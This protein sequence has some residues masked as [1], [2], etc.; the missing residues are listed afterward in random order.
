MVKGLVLTCAPEMDKY[1]EID[2]LSELDVLTE[3]PND[4]GGKIKEYEGAKFHTIIMEYPTQESVDSVMTILT[5]LEEAAPELIKAF[6]WDGKK[7]VLSFPVLKDNPKDNN[8]YQ[9]IVNEL[10]RVTT[11]LISENNNSLSIELNQTSV[12]EKLRK[13]ISLFIKW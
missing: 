12:Q 5:V 4:S 13:Y 2:V 8:I 7:V 1:T 11:F 10:L 3:I 6:L 9:L